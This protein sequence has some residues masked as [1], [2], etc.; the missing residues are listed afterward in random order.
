MIKKKKTDTI[1]DIE[2]SKKSQLCHD[3]SNFNFFSTKNSTDHSYCC[4]VRAHFNKLQLVLPQKFVL[5]H[6]CTSC[7]F[8]DINYSFILI[9]L[10]YFILIQFHISTYKHTIYLNLVKHAN[11]PCLLSMISIF[12]IVVICEVKNN[13]SFISV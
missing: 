6:S 13:L 1:L 8:K 7:W 12:V 11:L 5:V 2:K 9:F 3:M 4:P 10:F